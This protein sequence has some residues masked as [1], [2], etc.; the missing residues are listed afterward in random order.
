M[1]VTRPGPLIQT[2]PRPQHPSSSSSHECV[3][4][5][6]GLLG[7]RHGSLLQARSFLGNPSVVSFIARRW[8]ASC[9]LLRGPVLGE[10]VA[11]AY[12]A[13]FVRFA[14]VSGA[15]APPFPVSRELHTYTIF[16]ITS[17]HSTAPYITLHYI[18]LYYITSHH[19]T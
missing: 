13:Q 12:S 2:F 17:H 10:L 4:A 5:V 11:L 7:P 1:A 8:L 6:P 15:A 19:N 14:G 3:T 9:R 18:T 16:C